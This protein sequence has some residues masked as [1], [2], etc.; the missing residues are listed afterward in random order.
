MA[1]DILCEFSGWSPVTFEITECP[2]L[3]PGKQ[4]TSLR[5]RTFHN[6]P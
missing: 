5:L 3:L 4:I 2:A 1:M 6:T